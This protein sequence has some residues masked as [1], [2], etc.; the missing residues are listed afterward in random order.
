MRVARGGAVGDHGD[1]QIGGVRGIVA[2][3]H[4]ENRGEAAQALCP[5][6]EFID[7]P[8]QLDSRLFELAGGAARDDFLDVDVLHEGLFGEEHGFFGGAADT[9]AEYAGR[10]PSGAHGGD[11]LKNPVNDGLRGVEHGELRFG[12]GTSAL[13]SDGDFYVAPAHELDIDDGRGVVAGV[14]ARKGRVGEDGGAQLVV[15]VQI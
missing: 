7:F 13:G 2:N 14:A 6:T 8:V 10:A 1:R 12:L 9:D 4:I 15:R 3:L 5:D 11:G